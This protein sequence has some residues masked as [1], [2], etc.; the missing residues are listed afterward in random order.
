MDNHSY[1][2]V[3]YAGNKIIYTSKTD[4]GVPSGL[5][6]NFDRSTKEAIIS[7]HIPV[8]SWMVPK[9]AG[10]QLAYQILVSSSKEKSDLNQGNLWDSKQIRGNKSAN[11]LY[12]GKALNSAITYYWKVRIW[13]ASNRNSDYAV[14]QAFK[15]T[16]DKNAYNHPIIYQ[17]DTI[18]PT[19]FKKF[20]NILFIDFGKDVFCIL[21]LNYKAKQTE[22][23]TIKLGEQLNADGTINMK[24]GTSS[25]RAQ[26]IKLVV[27]PNQINYPINLK[28]DER[29]TK[30][31]AAQMPK[32]FPVLMPFRYV[33]IMGNTAEIQIEDVTQFAYH[34]Y[35][36]DQASSFHSS[37]EVLNQIWDLCKYSI[38]AT[39]FT[40]VY[41][42]GDRERIPYEA[43]AYIN[44]LS[45]YT[46]DREYNI[47]KNTIAYFM[48]FPTWPTE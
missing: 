28:K 19:Q 40:G 41:V 36:D 16:T 37:N 23:L 31:Q 25:T 6:V 3:G 14:S 38:K 26:E 30:P 43:D 46:T 44:Q 15:I 48:E 27:N 5:T 45:H 8:F 39:S 11:I 2:A 24:V 35:F 34:T 32:A 4:S 13:D 18:K 22:T 10:S 20:N 33:E 1:D 12:T 9:E 17:I 21:T 42:V 7:D 47:A 29:N